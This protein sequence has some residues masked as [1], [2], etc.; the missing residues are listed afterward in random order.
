M[1][2]GWSMDELSALESADEL[3]IATP[4]PDGTV[5]RY[6]PIWVVCSSRHVYVRTWHRRDTGWFGRAARTGDARI[7]FGEH[8][9]DVIV[10]DVG[11]DVDLRPAVDEAYR[12]KY[13]R[14]GSAT[15]DRMVG[16]DA[17]RTTLR[18]TPR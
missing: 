10:D 17:G 13:G 5:G 7:R 12:T 3:E 11:S 14:Y 4:R 18:L 15:V 1:S 16:D 2:T 6:V 9:I 8:E